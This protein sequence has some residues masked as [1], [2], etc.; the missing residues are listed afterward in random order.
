MLMVQS[1][2]L[3]KKALAA[4]AV[5]SGGVALLQVVA[6]ASLSG[7]LMLPQALL[8]ESGLFLVA[9][10]LVLVT[11]ARSA[12]VASAIVMLIVVGN[13]GWAVACVALVAGNV[14]TPSTLGL[15]F[16]TVQVVSVLA[17]AGLEWAGLRGSTVVASATDTARRTT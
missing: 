13:I 4:D 2:S 6:S 10:T 1:S 5:V 9:Y 17:F 14:V 16:L 12:R 8:F 11:L 7:L 3:L 15:A